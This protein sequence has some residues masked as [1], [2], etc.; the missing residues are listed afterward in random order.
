MLA[1]IRARAKM[2]ELRAASEDYNQISRD[3]AALFAL[4]VGILGDAAAAIADSFLDPELATGRPQLWDDGDGSI[5]EMVRFSAIFFDA[6]LDAQLEPDISSEFSLLCATSYYLG[7]SVGSA[8]VVSKRSELPNIALGHGLARL[9]YSILRSDYQ[10]IEESFVYHQFSIDLLAALRDFFDLTGTELA[11]RVLCKRLKTWVY[12]AGS[13]RELLYADIVIALCAKKLASACRTILPP[14]SLLTLADWAPALR[15]S[16]FPTE[17][18]P[19][20]KLICADGLLAG[21]SAVVQMPTSAGKTRSTEFLIRAHFLAKRSSLVVIVAPFRSLCH[22]IRSDMVRAFNGENT[23]IDEV[24]DSYLFDVDFKKIRRQNSVFIM[25][26]EKLLYM[27]RR[28]PELAEEIGLALFDEGHQF[29]GFRRGPSYELLLSSMRISLPSTAQ[30]ILISAVITNAPQIADWLVG[31]ANAVVHGKSLLPTA[32]NI[33][34][35]SWEFERAWLKYV[36]PHDPEQMEFFVPRVVASTVLQRKKKEL[37]DRLFPEKSTT[38]THT[39]IGLFLGLHLAENGSV[40][41]FCGTKESVGTV[42]KRAVDIYER[43]FEVT[44]PI[45]YSDAAEIRRIA[46]LAGKH[47]GET[48]EVA[49][50]ASL[51]ILSHHSNSPPGLRLSIEHAMKAGLAK[52]V[53]CTS[54][55]A[56]GVNFPIR[57]LIVTSTQQGQ[58]EIKVR[59][60]HNLM[61]RSGRAGMYT[62]G[63]VIFSAPTLIDQKKGVGGWRWDKAKRLLDP[64]QSEPASSSILELFANFNQPIPLKQPLQLTIPDSWLDLTFATPE[65]LSQLTKA[66]TDKFPMVDPLRYR[67]YLADRA[68]AVQSIAAYLANYVDFSS[69]L[70]IERV[71]ELA[72]NTLAY[73]LADDATRLR[74][75]NVFATTAKA[76]ELAGDAGLIEQIRRSPLPP[77]DIKHISAWTLANV[78]GLEALSDSDLAEAI[79]AKAIEHVQAPVLEKLDARQISTCLGGWMSGASYYELCLPLAASG[80]RIGVARVTPNHVVN[81]CENGFSY[82]LAMVISSIADLI[83]PVA[84]ALYE[85]LVVLQK[86]VKFGLESP[87]AIAF[88]EA[89]FA[90][91]VVA[92]SLAEKF[93]GVV[94]RKD[95]GNACRKESDR[96]AEVL[97]SFPSFFKYVA[98]ELRT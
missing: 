86:R 82:D 3:P 12:D 71:N 41:V 32:R 94:D 83:E 98:N 73:H 90:D 18:W 70:A 77:L 91:R 92:Q 85:R 56:Q 55:L 54:T 60:F 52:M 93:P 65:H 62:E 59:D 81:I 89:G 23:L 35:A 76:V 15:K 19:A 14:S 4:A 27:L 72:R 66:V 64:S 11:I 10:P 87:A 58:E 42:C 50:A 79:I 78:A 63:N 9:A 30:K 47:L 1:S 57:Y 69:D 29:D 2:H 6:Y 37:V 8:A 25:T 53:V 45:S 46:A 75:L 49:R 40:A 36:S 97:Q 48:S 5:A 67:A 95:A 26:P 43:K 74:L 39:D 80:L 88:F 31:D 21:R 28:A 61:G 20:Q 84:A 22:D 34:F 44:P 13:A 24:S 38:R 68:R 7:E 33:A 96:V 51:G 17:L 16:D